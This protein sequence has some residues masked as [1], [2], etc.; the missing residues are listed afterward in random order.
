MAPGLG[1]RHKSS[2]LSGTNQF[3]LASLSTTRASLISCR[4]KIALKNVF[5]P[6]FVS[7]ARSTIN[8][9]LSL[10]PS[11]HCLSLFHSLEWK[12]ERVGGWGRLARQKARARLPRGSCVNKKRPTACYW[13]R[14][15]PLAPPRNGLARQREM[16]SNQSYWCLSC[17]RTSVPYHTARPHLAVR[18]QKLS[19]MKGDSRQSRVLEAPGV[20]L[21][22]T[23]RGQSAGPRDQP[24]WGQSGS[25]WRGLSRADW[26]RIFNH[27]GL[28]AALAREARRVLG[29]HHDGRGGVG[30]RTRSQ[31]ARQVPGLGCAPSRLG[32]SFAKAT[33]EHKKKTHTLLSLEVPVSLSSLASSSSP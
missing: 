31:V 4:S 17:E 18:R 25:A 10:S 5:L 8:H 21:E 2:T 33:K 12:D 7:S 6:M 9:S 28:S 13:R 16:E 30:F 32:S 24:N 3:S 22:L 14:R 20:C 27:N 15:R 11:R 29:R 23:W 26:G 1:A 19:V